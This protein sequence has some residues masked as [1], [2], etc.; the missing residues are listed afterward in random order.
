M[1]Q[2]I[3]QML[4][5]KYRG[6][7]HWAKSGGHLFTGLARRAVNFEGFL[8]V[9]ERFDPEGVFSNDWTDALFGIGGKDVEK[10]RD[11]C[12]LKKTCKCREDNHCAPDKGFL[13]KP[14]RVWEHARVCR[15]IH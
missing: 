7:L 1:Y 3:E 12:A 8:K 14:G 9:K 4:I 11:G 13:C 15:N 6:G 5:E 10:L 2:E